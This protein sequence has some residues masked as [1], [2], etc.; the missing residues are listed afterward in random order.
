MSAH[1]SR[2]K[3]CGDHDEI[4]TA[5]VKTC[6]SYLKKP[7]IGTDKAF[8]VLAEQLNS[9]HWRMRVLYYDDAVSGITD[10]DLTTLRRR[11]AQFFLNLERKHLD[12]AEQCR[13]QHSALVVD[14][15]EFGLEEETCGA[16]SIK[17]GQQ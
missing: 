6:V 17:Y 10:A 5:L 14:Q 2:R 11:V 12:L 15:L 3:S 16:D 1:S 13:A 9:S 8:R 4:A 7:G